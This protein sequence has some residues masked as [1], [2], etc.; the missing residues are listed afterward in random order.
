MKK[1]A[2]IG[3][4]YLQLPLIQ[5][6]K[7]MGLETHV[8]AWAANDVGEAAADYFYPI[9]IVEKDAILAKCREVGIDGICS[10]A[11][12]L[13]M[14]TVNYV[15]Q[16]MDL[17][18]NSMQCTEKSTNKHKMREAFAQHGDPSPKSLLVES[19]DDLAGI[20]LTYPVI[21]KPTDRSGSRGITKLESAIGL[22]TAIENAKAQAF[23]KK[24]LV[25]EFAEGQEYSV[26]CISWQGMHH[27]LAL[28]QKYTTGAPGFIETGHLEP[29]PVSE[30]LLNRVKA[31]VFHALDSLEIRFGASHSELKIDKTGKIALIEIGGR[32]GGDFIGSDL[33]EL[34]TGVDFVKA[35]IDVALG[36]P[37]ELSRHAHS[38]AAVRFVFSEKDVEILRCI[39]NEHPEILV[40][41]NVAAVFDH[42]VT[43]SS[44]RFGYYLLQSS[45]A[46]LLISYMPS[47]TDWQVGTH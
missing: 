13:A 26:E 15:A 12:D 11:S 20:A 33:V 36:Q 30:E 27:F 35:V 32:M 29:A 23:E 38:A 45:D 8:F 40:R 19:T 18:G 39:Q 44:S 41:E 31:V 42:A 9:S 10:I 7:R 14:L 28:T 25:E 3:A 6:A 16:A 22:S 37:P 4:S 21:V 24:A 17:T 46:S 34:S 5:K 47:N 43:D 1:L 2:I